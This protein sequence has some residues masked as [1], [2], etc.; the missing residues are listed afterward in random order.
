M[1]DRFKTIQ[2]QLSQ[3]KERQARD[4][5]QLE[6]LEKEVKLAKGT[7]SAVVTKPT[8]PKMTAQ[9]LTDAI[10]KLTKVRPLSLQELA[11]SLATEPQVVSNVITGLKKQGHNMINGGEAR[12]ARWFYVPKFGNVG[13]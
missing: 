8:Q 12:R 4:R 11:T 3:I 6:A 10:I 9:Q 5:L 2:T 13:K 7:K 1:Q